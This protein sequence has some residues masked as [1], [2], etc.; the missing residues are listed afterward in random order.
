MTILMHLLSP[1][2]LFTITTP[3]FFNIWRF[4][5][6]LTCLAEN[7]RRIFAGIDIMASTEAVWNVSK[8]NMLLAPCFE[9]A[10]MFL[11]IQAL[12]LSG[13]SSNLKRC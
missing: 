12:L 13:F 9:G 8:R 6:F 11:L 2:P 7:S 10:V 1:L 5:L 3:M 4:A